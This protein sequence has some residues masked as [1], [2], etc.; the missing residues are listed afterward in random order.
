ML[1]NPFVL[2]SFRAA[3]LRLREKYFVCVCRCLLFPSAF[4]CACAAYVRVRGVY[5]C[6][7]LYV[8]ACVACLTCLVRVFCVRPRVCA[9]M[10]QVP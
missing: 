5:V 4:I 3:A 1:S 8:R 7:R 6:A 9:C 2:C 10:Y